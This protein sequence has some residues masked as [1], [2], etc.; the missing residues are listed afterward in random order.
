MFLGNDENV[1]ILD[2]AE[3]NAARIN[4]HPAWGSRW[5]I[6]THEATTMEVKTNS[7]CASG[8]FL[9]D[10]S[11][12]SFG[13]NDAVT[14]NGAAGS[15][16][17][18]DGTGLWDSVYND[19][20]GRRAIRL[21]KPCKASAGDD[22]DS[23]ACQ[24]SD[25]PQ[26]NGIMMQKKRWYSAAEPLADGT[27]IIIGGFVNGGYINRWFPMTDTVTQKGQA[28]N[29]YEYYP[30]RGDAKIVNFLT[31]TGGL[32]S[33]VHTFLMPSGKLLLQA[34]VSTSTCFISLKFILR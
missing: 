31:Q 23:V 30:A 2:K 29:S 24:W 1:Y 6:Q 8:M 34:N 7:F 11:W 27:V 5:N 32:N 17:N 9:P 4:G 18:P 10:G 14:I 20:D 21:L 26:G 3:G 16:K 28:E 22:L 33:Y 25:E 12:A 19:F 15:Q 13:G